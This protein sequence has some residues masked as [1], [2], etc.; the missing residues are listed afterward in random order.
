MSE[1]EE[2]RRRPDPA[3]FGPNRNF[4]GALR[5]DTWSQREDSWRERFGDGHQPRNGTGA[6]GEGVRVGYD[7]CEEQMRD[8]WRAA[9]HYN[10]GHRE[11][12]MR[13]HRHSNSGYGYRYESPP[14]MRPGY[15]QLIPMLTDYLTAL[16]AA[17]YPGMHP[18]H[19]H[20]RR[21][22]W[23]PPQSS[24]YPTSQGGTARH[25]A[26]VHLIFKKPL[27]ARSTLSLERYRPSMVLHLLEL[28][29]SSQI[30]HLNGYAETEDGR[31]TLHVEI[32]GPSGKYVG[33]IVDGDTQDR[34]GTLTVQ[35]FPPPP[36]ATAESRR[37]K[38]K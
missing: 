18:Y 33:Q 21:P 24:D 14:W 28:Q 23:Y 27:S 17:V 8:G 7:I 4:S 38:A 35:V 22:E 13:D 32:D 5:P 26:H 2:R 19:P 12:E 31:T 15:P 9:E 34:L 36:V 25:R 1:D 29:D 20:H 10:G 11:E 30:A 3:R 16:C 37:K 6:A